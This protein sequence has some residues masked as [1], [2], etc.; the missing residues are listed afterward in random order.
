MITSVDVEKKKIDKI[1]HPFMTKP[2]QKW[3]QREHTSTN[4]DHIQQAHR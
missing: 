3:V 4:R 2:Q 1:Q